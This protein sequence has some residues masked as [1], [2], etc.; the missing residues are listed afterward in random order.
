MRNSRE[1]V[2]DTLLQFR[3]EAPCAVGGDQPVSGNDGCAAGAIRRQSL[4]RY[5]V[6]EEPG[7]KL[8][9]DV[10]DEL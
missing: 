6:L 1:C 2:R 9:H 4:E 10:L 5:D 7:G 3:A 8:L